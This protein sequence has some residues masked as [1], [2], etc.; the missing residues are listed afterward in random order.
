MNRGPI[1]PGWNLLQKAN[2]D[3]SDAN[4]P[5]NGYPVQQALMGKFLA[6]D[7]NADRYMQMRHDYKDSGE[8]LGAMGA[9][10]RVFQY[11][12]QKRDQEQ[13]MR[14]LALAQLMIDPNDPTSQ[15][16]AYLIVPELRE[17]PESYHTEQL[18]LQET[19]RAMLLDGQIRSPQDHA[20][21][22]HLLQPDTVLPMYPTWDPQ[23]IIV[24]QVKSEFEKMYGTYIAQGLWDPKR[25]DHL[26][27]TERDKYTNT[28]QK[29]IKAFILKRLY[30]SIR[31]APLST[32]EELVEKFQTE[33]GFAYPNVGGQNNQ[34][35]IPGIAPDFT[36][37]PNQWFSS[38]FNPYVAPSNS[39]NNNNNNGSSAPQAQKN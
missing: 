25:W 24:E 26:E 39:S 9:D 18:A 31:T 8:P 37:S 33:S 5:R 6:T 36:K 32:A 14:Y 11:W 15:E 2:G 38:W 30:Q 29:K 27:K 21:V 22:M 7:P 23:G 16:R 17:V 3:S 4:N 10:D 20:L 13:Y 19:L 28:A 1:I 35:G 12:D 34:P